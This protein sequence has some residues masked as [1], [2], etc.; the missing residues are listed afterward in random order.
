MSIADHDFTVFLH[1]CARALLM[2]HCHLGQY[3][4]NLTINDVIVSKVKLNRKV[5]YRFTNFAVVI[6]GK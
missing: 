3:V 4:E 6:I 2:L 1:F 5:L